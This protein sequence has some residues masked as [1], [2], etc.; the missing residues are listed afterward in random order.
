L[1]RPT[2]RKTPSYDYSTAPPDLESCSGETP[3]HTSQSTD[4]ENH[5]KP[6]AFAPVAFQP[7]AYTR[8]IKPVC[9]RVTAL[10]ALVLL[11]VPMLLIVAAVFLSMGL[12][13]LFRQRRV[14]LNGKVF[15]VLKFRTM[16]QDRREKEKDVSEDLRLTHKTEKD[17]R[18]TSVGQFLRRYSLDELPQLFNVL[19]GEMSLIGPRPELESIVSTQY[20]AGLEQ[21]HL[22]RP[23]LTGLWQ[24]S[25]RG[26]GHMHENGQWDL[27]Y[28]EAISPITDLRIL[29]KTPFVMF[30]RNAGK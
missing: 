5:Q 27:D 22:V 12:P 19:R 14:G 3:N 4:Q 2:V 8:I 11:A 24:I 6:E 13:L 16:E 21:R 15:Y 1:V 18:H 29:F 30:G 26:E 28:V 10:V 7:T 20:P 25:V 9:D 23:G 17:P